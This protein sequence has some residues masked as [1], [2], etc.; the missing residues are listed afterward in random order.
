MRIVRQSPTAR[1]PTGAVEAAD[2]R[3]GLAGPTALRVLPGNERHAGAR[4]YRRRAGEIG[5][6]FGQTGR[7]QAGRG[8]SPRK[9]AEP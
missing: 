1:T 4:A 3:S 8:L 7:G 9:P 2:T 5:P 6:G